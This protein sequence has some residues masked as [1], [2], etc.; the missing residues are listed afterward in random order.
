VSNEQKLREYLRR[1]VAEAQRAN[2]ELRAV[3]ERLAEPIAVVAMSCRFPGSVASAQ[4]L[5]QLVYDGVDAISGF[6]TDRGWDMAGSRLRGGGFLADVAGFDA[7]LFGISPREA[8]AMDPQQRLLLECCWEVF[9]RA[10]LDPMSLRD[11][12]TGVFV[13]AIAQDYGARLGEGSLGYVLTGNTGS[14]VSGRVAYTFGL[15][16]PAVT[17]DTACSSSLVAL[18]SACVALRQ[19]ECSLALAGGVTAMST[20]DGI[21]DFD[22]QG[23]LSVDGRCRAFAAGADGFGPAEGVGVLLLARLSEARRLGYPV[24]AVIRGSAVNSDGASNGLTAPNGTSQQQVIQAALTSAGLSAEDVDVVEAHG[25]G[26]ALGDSIEAQAIMATYGRRAAD[27]PLW[28]G[29]VKSNIGHAQAAA[30]V[31]G[32]IKMV[33]AIRHGVLPRTLHADRPTDQVDWSSGSVRLLADNQPWPERDGNRRAA[34]SSFGISGTNAHLIIEQVGPTADRPVPD[35]PAAEVLPYLL[36]GRTAEALRAQAARLLAHVERFPDLSARDLAYS[37]A[38]SRAA[39]DHRAVLIAGERAELV[40]GLHALIAGEQAPGLV[41]GVAGVEPSVA[42]V[43]PGQGGQWP[44]MAAELMRR[45]PVFAESMR[46]CAAALESVVD[47]SVPDVVSGVEGAASLD[48]VEVVQPVLFAVAVSLAAVWRSFGV[49]PSAVVGHSQGEIAA[50]CVAGGL[51]L[52]DAARIVAVRSQIIAED[53]AGQGG[54]MSFPM[55]SARVERL[56]RP[57]RDRVG[58]AAVNGPSSVVISGERAALAEIAAASGA[59]GWGARTI[60]VD[61]AS[62]S[63]QVSAIRTRLRT[64][65][66]EPASRSSEIP[67]FS[68]VIA[69]WLDTAE[70]DGE[71]WYR[72]LREPVRFETA[73]ESLAEAGFSAFI[74]VGPHP[75]LT[76]GMQDTAAGATVVGTLRRD[77]GGLPRLLTSL[78]ELYV[79]GVAVDFAPLFGGAAAIDLPTYAFQRQRYWLAPAAGGDGHPWLGAGVELAGGTGTLFTGTLS[80]SGQPWLRDHTVAGGV[81]FPGSGFVEICLAVGA[82]LGLS[83]VDD[84]TLH[85]P[86]H[87]TDAVSVQVLVGPADADGRRAVTMHARASSEQDWTHHASAT[88]V[89]GRPWED[90]AGEWPTADAESADDLY[91]ELARRGYG[92]GPAFRAVRAWWRRGDEVFAEL[93]LPDPVDAHD[94]LLHPAL[95]DAALHPAGA[96]HD[97]CLLPFAWH[98]VT[99]HAPVT[100]PLRVHVTVAAP[101]ELRLRIADS[102]GAPVASVERMVLRP[103]TAVTTAPDSLYEVRWIDRDAPAAV[104]GNWLAIRE[105]CGDLPVLPDLAAVGAAVDAGR[106]V[107]ELVFLRTAGPPEATPDAVSE[108]VHG[109]L[110]TVRAWLADDR[111]GSSRLVF[112]TSGAVPVDEDADIDLV[113]APVWGLVR[114]AQTEHPDRFVLLDL[115]TDPRSFP[116][117]SSSLLLA[118]PQLA[119]R[120]GQV[121]IPRLARLSGQDVFLPSD[122]DWCLDVVGGGSIEDVRPVRRAAG[123]EPL[124]EGQVRIAV[125]AAG[126]NFRDVTLTLGLVDQEGLGSEGAGVVTEI[127]PAVSGLR[128][129]DR[130]M[131]LWANGFAPDV[132]ADARLVTPIPQGWS[133]ARA[134][135]V[136]VAF[137][138]A[139]YALVDLAGVTEGET[140]L[141]HACAG[142]V[143]MAAVQLA[144]VLGARVFGTASPAKWPAVREGLRQVASSR[145]VDFRAEFLATTGGAGVDVV[146]NSLTGDRLDASLDL[147]VGGGRFVELGKTDLRDP[148]TV[149]AA[150]PAVVYQAFDLGAVDPDRLRAILLEVLDLFER[151]RL[152]PPPVTTWRMRR[153]REAFRFMAQASHIGKLVLTMPG[154]VDPNG[155]VLITGGTGALGT[156]LARHLV[157]QHGVRRLVLLSRQG[158]DAPGAAELSAELSALGAEV[159]TLAGDTADPAVVADLVSGHQLTGVVHAAGVLDDGMLESLTEQQIQRV[160]RPKVTA[161][162]ALHEATRELDLDFFVLFSSLSGVLGGAGQAHYAAANAF[163]DALAVHRGRLGLAATSLAWGFWADRSAMTG[164]LGGADLHRISRGGVLPLSTEEAL[165][166]FDAAL[167]ADRS[168]LAPARL[169][170]A[171]PRTVPAAPLRSLVH[172]RTARPT[173]LVDGDPAGY[174]DRLARLSDT[175]Q[176]DTL[177]HLVRTQTAIVLGHRNSMEI[178]A[179]RAFTDSGFDSLTATELRNRLNAS[180]GLRLPATVVFDH[181]NPALLAAHLRRELVGAPAKPVRPAPT[182]A[183]TG[184]PIAIIG[185]A[186]RFPGGVASP[187]DLWQLLVEE[188]NTAAPFPDDRGW[189]LPGGIPSQGSFLSGAGDFD[190][191][192]FGISPREALAMDPQQRL[193]LEC[194][195][196]AVERARIAPHSLRGSQTGVF[197]GAITQEYGPRLGTG[198]VGYGFTGNTG[199]V[200]SGRVAYSFGFEGPAVTVDTACSSSLVALHWAC[201]SLRRG[202]SELA[203]AGGV[204]VVSSV[205]GVVEFARQGALSP[206]GRC[207]AYSDE[208]D[209]FGA[210]EGVGVLVLERLSDAV[211]NGRRVWGVVRGSAV[212]SDGASNGLTAPSGG[213]QVRVIRQALVDAGVGVGDVGVVEGHGTGTVLG[214][215]IEVGALV[216]TYG[217]S[218]VLLGSVKSNIGHAQAAAGVAGVMKV[219]LGMGAGVVPASLFAGEGG[220]DGVVVVREACVWPGE[221]LRAGVSSF[222]ISGTNAH[223]I[224]EQAPVQD[225]PAGTPHN[226]EALPWVLSGHTDGALRAQAAKLLA[227]VE[228]RPDLAPP[229]VAHS[230]VTTRAMLAHRAVV[231]GRD[232]GELCAGVRALADGEPAAAVVTGVR[233]AVGPAVLVFPGQGTQWHGMAAELMRTN[234]VFAESMRSCAEVI[235][236]QVDYSVLDVATGVAGAASLERVDVVQPVLFAVSVSL[237]A[238]W[239]SLG[240]RPSAVVGHSQGEIAAACVAG[241]LSLPDAA[242]IVVL[243]S[244]LVAAGLSGKGGMVV[245]EREDLI[246]DRVS[247]AARNGPS[248]VVVS[249]DMADLTE[250]VARY[251]AGGLRATWVAVDYASHSAQ[252][253]AL[254]SDLLAGLA[255]IAARH[256]DIPM[257][258]T[259]TGDWVNADGLGREYWFRNLREPVRFGAAVQSL[260]EQGSTVFVEMSAHPVLL[261]AMQDVLGDHA[262][263]V[264]SLRRDDGGVD[265]LIRSAAQLFV[266]GVDIDWSGLVGR[267]AVVELPTYAF[268]RRR[269]W[270]E[271]PATTGSAP[272]IAVPDE[273]DGAVAAIPAAD[274]PVA[275]LD[276]VRGTVAAVFGYDGRDAVGAD[277]NLLRLGLDSLTALELRNHL[278]AATGRRLPTTLA[279][280]HPSPRLITEF[281]L[282]LPELEEPAGPSLR[283]VAALRGTEPEP[284][285]FHQQRLWSL[286]KMVPGI[287]AYNVALEFTLD[288]ALRP[289]LLSDAVDRTVARHEVLRT[290]FPVLDGEPRQEIAPELRIPLP[291]VDLCDLPEDERDAE[292]D[293]IAGQEARHVFDLATGPLVRMLLVRLGPGRHRL[294]LVMHHIITDAWS[295]YLMLREI[296]TSYQALTAGEPVVLPDLPVQYRDFTRWERERMAGA[297]LERRLAYWR[298]QLGADRSGLV[299]PV[300]R[301]RPA[302]QTFAGDSLRFQVEPELVTALTELGQRHDVTLFTTLI[303]TL[304]VLLHRYSGSDDIVI[305]TPV[306]SRHHADIENLLGFFV[307]TVVLRTDLADDP[308][309]PDLLTRVGSVVRDAF[310]HQD[311]PFELLVADLLPDRGLSMNPLF[312]VCFALQPSMRERWWEGSILT[313]G[314]G[315]PNGTCKFDLWISL[316]EQDGG[317]SGEVEYSTDLFERTTVERI[318]AAYQRLLG[319]L[320]AQPGDRASELAVMTPEMESTLLEWNRTDRDYSDHGAPTLHQLVESAV[321]SWPDRIAV[322]TEQEHVTFAELDHRANQ[323][324]HRLRQLGVGRDEPVG[325]CARRSVELVT[326]LLGVLKAGGAYLPIDPAYPAQRLAFLLADAAPR[327]LLTQTDLVDA[328]PAHEATV[329]CLD[330]AD[331]GLADQPATRPCLAVD[332]DD[333]AYLIYTSGSTGTPKAAMI[334]HRAIRNRL[335]WMQEEYRLT[336]EDLVLQKTPFSFDVSVWEF[337]W[338]LL[339]GARMVLARPEGHRDPRYLTELIQRE[340]ITVLHFVPSMLRVFLEEPGVDRCGSVRL[341]FA[342]GEQLSPSLA[343]RCQERLPAAALHNLYGPTEAAVDVTHWP[344]PA[345]SASTIVPIGRPVANTRIH[346]VDRGLRRVPIGAVG[347]LCISGVQVARGYLNRPELTVER[348]VPDPFQPGANLYRTG[349]LARYLPDGDIVYLGRTDFQ[350]KVRGLRI[351]P[352]EIELAL[353]EHPAVREAVVLARELPG[354]EGHQQLVGYVVPHIAREHHTQ[355]D[356]GTEQVEQWRGVFE[357]TYDEETAGDTAEFNIAGWNS[358][359]T[360]EPLPAEHMRIWVDATVRRIRAF[361]PERVLEIGCGTG[362]LLARVAPHTSRYCATDISATALDHVRERIVPGL[363]S[364]VEVRLHNCAAN[365]FTMLADEEFDLVV[366]NSVAQYFPDVT[367]LVDVISGAIDRLRPGGT[368]FLGDLRSLSLLAAFHTEVE[369]CRAAPETTLGQL[370]ARVHTRVSQERELVLDPDFFLA[371]RAEIP[372]I[373]RIEVLLKRGEHH[374]ELTRYRYD[375]ALHIGEPVTAEPVELRRVGWAAVGMEGVR[376]ILTTGAPRELVVDD[377]PNARTAVTSA[378]LAMTEQAADSTPLAGLPLPVDGQGVEPERWWELADECGYRAAPAWTPASDD[379]RYLVILSRAGADSHTGWDAVAGPALRPVERCAN[380]P[381]LAALHRELPRELGRHL[382]DRLPDYMIPASLVVL[383]ELPTDANGKLD[384]RA[385]P[386]PRF[387]LAETTDGGRA[388]RTPEEAQLAALWAEVLGLERVDVST[389][390]FALGGDSLLVIRMASKAAALGMDLTPQDVFQAKTIADLAQLVSSRDPIT[391]PSRAGGEDGAYEARLSRL[392]ARYPD[393]VDV[394]PMTGIQRAILYRRRHTGESGANVIHH[395]FHI[396]SAEFDPAALEASWQHTVDQFPALRTGYLWDEDGQPVQVVH[397]GVQLRVARYDWRRLQPAEQE[398]RLQAEIAARRD[399]GFDPDQPPQMAVALFQL[400][401]SSYEYVYL[402]NLA[403]HDGWSYMIIMAVFLDAYEAITA[404]RTAPSLP[405]SAAYRDFCVTSAERDMTAAEAF[406]RDEL[407]GLQL[408]APVLTTER[409]ARPGPLPYVQETLLVAP[410]RA[411][412]L[413]ALARRFDLTV[414]TVVQAAWAIVLGAV[415]GSSEV[416]FGTVFSGRGSALIDVERAVGQFFNI[417]PVRTELTRSEPLPAWLTRLQRRIADLGRYEYLP[418]WTL[419]ELAGVPE[420]HLLFDSYVVNETFPELATN[421]ER[422]QRVLGATPKEFINQTEHPLRI[423]VALADSLLLI[424]FNFYADA[425][426]PDE[427]A[428][429]LASLDEV[430]TAFTGDERRTV[431]EIL[432]HLAGQQRTGNSATP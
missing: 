275:V 248:S 291:V 228:R 376:T 353:T 50:A 121:S 222:G 362:L 99:L 183:S 221:V 126:V 47:F 138:T 90:P 18:H 329:L 123:R 186:C 178:P 122:R 397:E 315:I 264:G 39:L 132:V 26:T 156:R 125:R 193:L 338:P 189:D 372:A 278:T 253:D 173:G 42:M 216:R 177:L 72:N 287:P 405:A 377:V 389:S 21:V 190:A 140:V 25:T 399:R 29:S 223:V 358:S 103:A 266:R 136:P 130:V 91:D 94:Y 217:E 146:V 317:L 149:A 428:G 135:A 162:L 176:L 327:V 128:V 204:T 75:V 332:P 43:F 19:D 335:L 313:G 280:D 349:D 133:F 339:R 28:L 101:T 414:Y 31:A 116:V 342:S 404:G 44:G 129:G 367:Y 169:D 386:Q 46:S 106:A 320:V 181:P 170:P 409:P 299:L 368:L 238:V 179:E 385:L 67:F 148:A 369:I 279:F 141:I 366:I 258:S 207:K 395:R 8:L 206:D 383:A 167:A 272:A 245:V 350:L 137:V 35:R 232:R 158:P 210:G 284:L 271:P 7:E 352:G 2:G 396:D 382:R 114:S 430:F 345:E 413:V 185:M 196:E 432:D 12:A 9:E 301:P 429:W 419:C 191:G 331:N 5:W 425:F 77:D 365:D 71:Y 321:D 219:V 233:N 364:G 267:A 197:V 180:T 86:L 431:G 297:A 48:R 58:V 24:L 83:G 236:P 88:L 30:G 59:N 336:T 269:Y 64:A 68:T 343:R 3:R 175:E 295:G 307:N 229:D 84:L 195:W 312:Q 242:R 32:V 361:G 119:V 241:A 375:V 163:L 192:F 187:E 218:G 239:R 80:P 115:D 308:A 85:V 4:D 199:S 209:G 296:L 423:E 107:P 6:P 318:I 363:P 290:S 60:P 151:G 311:L 282:G 411:A 340:R 52:A 273:F 155:T 230:L 234:A 17:L 150:R 270:L 250:L 420:G 111:F 359:Y 166:L 247:V 380:N 293:R 337:F 348:F 108:V 120:A 344:C 427:V 78:A 14:V 252:V 235:D 260:A 131:G 360:G 333:L 381:V 154:R 309:V 302:M 347:E 256:P 93:D 393:A 212:N 13:G 11:S 215:P 220:G 263:L 357:R 142:G 205:G 51:S 224:V 105:Q 401:E 143:G 40:A 53:L 194:C 15:R 36:A 110:G 38:A 54:M 159:I 283:E 117:L 403:E 378:W 57:W 417:L 402:F 408:P 89:A 254:R 201:Q 384:R 211:R 145:T 147:L 300:D 37:L 153:V 259:V 316:T 161:A 351:E 81:V 325:I 246:G 74:E 152:R 112:V 139:Y 356:A 172:T 214:D 73:V 406:W 144:N 374:D 322:W 298:G 274:R 292:F 330:D 412:A 79:R 87:L 168:T 328:L 354:Q 56:I 10:R 394:Y 41:T 261:G 66:G 82:R 213:A 65:L 49:R 203:L 277:D 225:L 373:S 323:L 27:R 426:G 355:G 407:A 188:R 202:E 198:L 100:G 289:D 95:L 134:A 92:Y 305:G 306:A 324:A 410:E 276:L 388:P 160:M 200:I 109:V 61:Y 243:R 157:A 268:Q 319:S 182:P 34:V 370:R 164:A 387:D 341:L 346:L 237:A 104:R 286:D 371:L 415:S 20:P 303:A 421:F 304:S 208:A 226:G 76:A 390:F 124:A 251:Q 22:T 70:L 255:P 113:T 288:G 392:R 96:G 62:H 314:R 23:A 391:V 16:G 249:G 418:P 326:G 171:A 244:R 98:G 379:G 231:V 97:T 127:G 102:T 285:S 1:A 165:R 265:R 416:V 281:L 118:E 174:R 184:E 55:P 227:F 262:V 240:L 422:F 69:D 33:Q 310:A 398:R 257:F 45:S 334:S 424:N 400:G 294:I 63:G